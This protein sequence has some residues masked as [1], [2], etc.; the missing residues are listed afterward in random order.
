MGFSYHEVDNWRH[1]MASTSSLTL[2]LNPYLD[3]ATDAIAYRDQIYISKINLSRDDLNYPTS[4]AS[5]ENDEKPGFINL[6]EITSTD[7]AEL[8]ACAGRPFS[9]FYNGLLFFPISSPLV[10]SGNNSLYLWF[11][12]KKRFGRAIGAAAAANLV[13]TISTE[14]DELVTASLSSVPIVGSEPPVPVV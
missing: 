3:T 10:D 2:H 7:P 8:E 4:V 14:D 9:L 5:A 12:A 6:L 13:I 11:L 1:T